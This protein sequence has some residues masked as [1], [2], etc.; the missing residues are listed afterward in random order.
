MAKENDPIIKFIMKIH[1]KHN[2]DNKDNKDKITYKEA[3][4]E[5]K[6]M[7]YPKG[8]QKYKF[9]GLSNWKKDKANH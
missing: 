8:F 1:N 2:K 6:R 5:F 7:Y 3:L 4:K 9:I